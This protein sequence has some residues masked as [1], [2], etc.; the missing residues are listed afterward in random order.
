M[1]PVPLG[2]SKYLQYKPTAP[3]LD[4][5]DGVY[6][7][8]LQRRQDRLY[9]FLQRSAL[10]ASKLHITTAFDG[11][12]LTWSPSLRK[13]FAGNHFHSRRALAAK[14]LS[15][16]TLWRHIASTQDEFHLVLEDDAQLS[17]EFVQ[18][19]NNRF[20]HAFPPNADIVFLGGVQAQNR[21]PYYANGTLSR[22]SRYFNKH[23]STTLFTA[24]W[25][26][27]VDQGDPS[28]PTPAFHY[29][30]VAYM[31]SS[32]AARDLVAMVSKYGLIYVST[33]SYVLS[34]LVISCHVVH[35]LSSLP[36]CCQAPALTHLLAVT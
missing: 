19:W 28:T 13:L 21:G 36:W 27:G 15:H 24:D 35:V 18:H 32:Q 17:A 1:V 12:E 30:S 9:S 5:V 34:Y 16:F 22:V 29:R 3:L 31:L 25:D 7:I 2:R 20:T 4:E 10:D 33:T 26:A 11:Q 8:N 23:L 14:G 6:L